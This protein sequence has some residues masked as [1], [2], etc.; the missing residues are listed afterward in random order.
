MLDAKA[1][2]TALK[3]LKKFGKDGTYKTATG[4]AY[5]PNT[6]MNAITYAEQSIKAYIDSPKQGEI[7]S[8]LVNVGDAVIL[9]AGSGLSVIPKVN[10]VIIFTERTYTVKRNMEVWSGAEIALHRLVC[11][12]R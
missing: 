4:E 12:I 10:D 2:A 1:R 9:V 3:L 8:G 11:E 7:E 5:D 6:S